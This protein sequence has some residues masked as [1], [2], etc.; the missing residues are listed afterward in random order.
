M[1]LSAEVVRDGS[2]RTSQK[3]LH[4]EEVQKISLLIYVAWPLVTFQPLSEEHFPERWEAGATVSVRPRT[5]P[6]VPV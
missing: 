3:S 5:S 6:Y 1:I 2:V 4:W